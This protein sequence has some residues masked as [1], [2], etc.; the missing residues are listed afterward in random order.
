[1]SA[2]D[3]LLASLEAERHNGGG[4][5]KPAPKRRPRKPPLRPR[6]R[7]AEVAEQDEQDEGAA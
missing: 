7:A 4:W 5:R 1:M 6:S 3:D 2:Y